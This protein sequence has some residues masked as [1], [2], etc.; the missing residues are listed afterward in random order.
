MKDELKAKIDAGGFAV[1]STYSADWLF[2]ALRRICE[3]EGEPVTVVNMLAYAPAL[4]SDLEHSQL[5]TDAD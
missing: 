1:L 5:T 2:D 4:D 3:G